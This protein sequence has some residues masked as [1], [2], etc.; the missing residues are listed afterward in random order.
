MYHAGAKCLKLRK[1]GK[2]ITKLLN[3]TAVLLLVQCFD[4]KKF[5]VNVEWST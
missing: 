4:N 2:F 3:L 5:L 1:N